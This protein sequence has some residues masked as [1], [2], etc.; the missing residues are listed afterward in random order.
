MKAKTCYLSYPFYDETAIDI[1]PTD[2][3]LWAGPLA[4]RFMG[5]SILRFD[6]SVC[7][8]KESK[9]FPFQDLRPVCMLDCNQF[10]PTLVNA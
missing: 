3:K 9:H 2:H 6:F 10:Y 5:S 1:S 7:P 8:H 4:P